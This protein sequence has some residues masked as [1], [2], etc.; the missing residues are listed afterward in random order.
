[1]EQVR[2]ARGTTRKSRWCAVEHREID[3]ASRSSFTEEFEVVIM[4]ASCNRRDAWVG[5]SPDLKTITSEPTVGKG[6]TINESEM[7]L[8]FDACSRALKKC[9]TRA[10]IVREDAIYRRPG[11][12]R[13]GLTPTTVVIAPRAALAWLEFRFGSD[14]R[15]RPD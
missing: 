6:N 7:A 8:F 10:D 4:I 12:C 11:S 2:F 3:W 1:M 9:L 15:R 13:T 5:L 14:R